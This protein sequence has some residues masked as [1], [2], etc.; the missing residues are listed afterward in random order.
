MSMRCRNG[1]PHTHETAEESRACW[2]SSLLERTN[3]T[4]LT[5]T[6]RVQTHSL[7]SAP[8]SGSA[9]YR[10]GE[11]IL[12]F[13]PMLEQVPEGYYAVQPDTVT[14]L[15]F[16]RVSRPTRKD[17]KLLGCTVIQRVSGPDLDRGAIVHPPSDWAPEQGPRV[18][19]YDH[20]VEDAVLLLVCDHM[21]AARRYAT[22]IGKCARCNLRLTDVRSR[23]YGIGPECERHWPWMIA[24]VDEQE[25]LDRS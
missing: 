3:A 8:P 6:P 11:K 12:K 23:H 10:G 4:R 15:F 13:L 25:E 18:T 9:S 24:N 7:S 20:R 14:P 2:N 22:E 21:G 5:P 19:L 17:S 16:L 1:I